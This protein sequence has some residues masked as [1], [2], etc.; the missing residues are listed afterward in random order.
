V[1]GVNAARKVLG[2]PAVVFGRHESYIGV[3]IDDLVTKGT[4]EPYRM[5]TSRAEYRLLLRQDNARFR[6]QT[7]AREIGLLPDD[8][9]RESAAMSAA[10]DREL[11][12][13]RETR[14]GGA[15]LDQVLRRTG[16]GYRDLVGSDPGLGGEEATQVEIAL[17]YEG[18]IV[19]DLQ[20]IG[21][22]TD[23]EQQAIP[24]WLV[25]EDIPALRYESR[26]KLSRVRPENL[27]QASR[28]SGISPADIAIL[29]VL[30]KR[31]RG[32]ARPEVGTG[33]PL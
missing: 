14:S 20:R 8:L 17:K 4:E 27:G 1:A 15:S 9:L 10:I 6:M 7:H 25:Y 30:I 11:A 3:L 29:A 19:R 18:Y 2:R 13:L 12:R 5:F 16:V 22:M 28:I 32:G 24:A 31:G 26:E 23:L 21:R 33:H